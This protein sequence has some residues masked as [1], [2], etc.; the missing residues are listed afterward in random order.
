MGDL[1]EA[2]VELVRRAATDLPEDVEQALRDARE[3]EA[4]SS[5]A[6]GALDTILEN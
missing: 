1:T 5:A 6:R 2:F 3:R 4:P